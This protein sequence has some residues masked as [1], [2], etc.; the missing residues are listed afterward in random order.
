M[1]C[2]V[3]CVGRRDY[4]SQHDHLQ[5]DDGTCVNKILRQIS[6]LQKIPSQKPA[7]FRVKRT[8]SVQCVLPS[9]MCGKAWLFISA[10]PSSSWWWDMCEQ[11][12]ATNSSMEILWWHGHKFSIANFSGQN[13]K[14]IRCSSAFLAT[15]NML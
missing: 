15:K 4:S 14:K 5:V 9:M 10:R 13:Y 3:W 11:N 7:F 8:D 1:C 12:I 2:L 6:F